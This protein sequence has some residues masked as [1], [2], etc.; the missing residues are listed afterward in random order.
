[1]RQIDQPPSFPTAQRKVPRVGPKPLL[2]ALRAASLTG[3]LLLIAAATVFA[4]GNGISV[5]SY[6][7]ALAGNARSRF[8]TAP[9]DKASVGGAESDGALTVSHH[10]GPF[11]ILS[12]QTRAPAA[13]S[14]DSMMHARTPTPG[15]S[16]AGAF[17]TSNPGGHGFT[18]SQV[19]SSG[20]GS[21]S[22]V[23]L[24][25]QDDPVLPYFRTTSTTT[26]TTTTLVAGTKYTFGAYDYVLIPNTYFLMAWDTGTTVRVPG[27][28]VHLRLSCRSTADTTATVTETQVTEN[29]VTTTTWSF[30]I[31]QGDNTKTTTLSPESPRTERVHENLCNLP[32]FTSTFD[33]LWTDGT[34][35]Y[36]KNNKK[37]VFEAHDIGEDP[38]AITRNQSKDIPIEYDDL[39]GT[40][41][42]GNG[43]FGDDAANNAVANT[44]WYA[45]GAR[46]LLFAY[47]TA[48]F[49]RVS[50]RDINV[51]D[52]IDGY[53][54]DVYL[55]ENKAYVA[56]ASY[57]EI[58]DVTRS[59]NTITV[60]APADGE[61]ARIPSI[62]GVRRVTGD[63]D[64]VHFQA[65]Q[66]S[67]SIAYQIS[68]ANTIPTGFDLNKTQYR[69]ADDDF[70]NYVDTM[71]IATHD[72]ET[73]YVLFPDGTID[74]VTRQE[75]EGVANV[76]T[77]PENSSADTELTGFARATSQ[78]PSNQVWSLDSDNAQTKCFTLS[79]SGEYSQTGALTTSDDTS[80]D[81]T[82]DHEKTAQYTI[83]TTV[84]TMVNNE[85][86]SVT[87]DI[88]IDVTDV[89][90][91]PPPPT[92]LAVSPGPTSVNASWTLPTETDMTGKPPLDSIDTTSGTG[93]A[94]PNASVKL[95]AA[96][97]T[98]DTWMGIVEN[99]EHTF[100]A[101]ATNH[102][103]SS[104][105][106]SAGY[107]TS[108]LPMI[109]GSSSISHPENISDI[110]QTFRVSDPDE[111]QAI[112]S[113]SIAGDDSALFTLDAT[114]EN[115]DVALSF[116]NSPNY[117]QAGDADTNNVYLL[118]IT[119]TS[120]SG[121]AEGDVAQEVSIA[122][123]DAEDPP[124]GVPT[125]AGDAT[126]GSTLTSI[127]EAVTDDDGIDADSWRYQWQRSSANAWVDISNA[128][129]ASYVLQ[130]SDVGQRV[131]VIASY[132]DGHDS[133]RAQLESQPTDTVVANQ[134]PAF[135]SQTSHSVA[136]NTVSAITIAAE[137]DDSEDAIKGFS[138]SGTDSGDFAI[139]NAGQLSFRQSPDFERPNDHDTDNNYNLTI[140]VTSGD[141][142]R[143]REHTADFTISVTDET[144]PPGK[145]SRPVTTKQTLSSL[146]FSWS[147]PANQGPAITGYTYRYDGGSG[148]TTVSNYASTLVEITGL[149]MDTEYTFQVN[150]TNDEGTG[151][152]S[153]AVVTSTKDNQP[154]SIEQGDTI[155]RSIPENTHTQT[156]LGD[157][158]TVTDPDIDDGGN[159]VWEITTAD[160]PFTITAGTGSLPN[161]Q[162]KTLAGSDYDQEQKSTYVFQVQVR[163]NQGGADATEVTVNVTD[164]AEPPT[165]PTPIA[166]GTGETWV[167]IRWLAPDNKGRP[168]ITS[169]NIRHSDDGNPPYISA[170]LLAIA[171]TYTISDL[172]PQTS[173][174]VS[175]QAVNDEGVSPWSGAITMTTGASALAPAPIPAP[176]TTPTPTVE[177]TPTPIPTATAT[178]TPTPTPTATLTPIPIPNTGSEPISRSD[179]VP[180]K[181]PTPDTAPLP[182]L[183]PT[184]SPPYEPTAAPTPATE[185]I[186]ERAD[187]SETASPTLTA[188]SPI[189]TPTPTPTP[190]PAVGHA[191]ATATSAPTP[192]LPHQNPGAFLANTPTPQPPVQSTSPQPTA[193]QPVT[194]TPTPQ[195]ATRNVPSIELL[196]NVPDWLW[197]II[198][199]ILLALILAIFVVRRLLRRDRRQN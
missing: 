149:D 198:L 44:I 170:R 127:V 51:S 101:R 2:V 47:D 176:A 162:I 13:F 123:T 143:V 76:F 89:D 174:D 102:E 152:W 27:Q 92:N 88:T 65:N 53:F 112:T 137:D 151:L 110:G 128:T 119:A 75:A 109:T 186:L 26:T 169:Y 129:M 8:A 154:P 158:L 59:D 185:L 43:I 3:L 118:T 28:E 116:K 97:A 30:T 179:G 124:Q 145:P 20:P 115:Q 113:V 7:D 77:L 95:L 166:D 188:R 117:E 35:I 60:E 37:M 48:T 69:P 49:R 17:P 148:W 199:G 177:P 150:A 178:P 132:T 79:T 189:L 21:G 187:D 142:P 24:N 138:I 141:G 86:E 100:C 25:S 165:A 133:D 66:N 73:L 105:W 139:T 180:T 31:S 184:A 164:V 183:V 64:F 56:G 197:W 190:T 72:D 16:H 130:S 103:G 83:S 182:R 36:V 58:Y 10:P 153:D 14:P 106:V 134:P 82:H 94:C 61:T 146:D 57:G 126:E 96:D 5:Q 159:I 42:Y 19:L 144:E 74:T 163:D 40:V 140:T 107:T 173:I 6:P 195:A 90:E 45:I 168:P 52:D 181:T 121:D 22:A 62:A 41:H 108:N 87:F 32:T 136:E 15:A 67:R 50:A 191:T 111:G 18:S 1:M 4:E 85:E 33:D 99:T 125:I 194:P 122:V 68:A 175:L 93:S 131:R 11:P 46:N 71:S 98:T 160:V 12:S 171:T 114:N 70:K 196:S 81:C 172:E 161:A 34:S 135:T 157:P 55:T 63:G 23:G 84:T 167:K 120:G 78:F 193:T 38:T 29:S 104:D 155:S 156:D 54:E 39:A 147:E 192:T 9:V 91:P 80:A